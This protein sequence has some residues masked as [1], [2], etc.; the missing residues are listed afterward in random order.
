VE[1]ATVAPPTTKALATAQ[2]TSVQPRFA[3]GRQDELYSRVYLGVIAL[4]SEANSAPA[5]GSPRRDVYLRDL[6]R[7]GVEPILTGAISSMVS[8]FVALG[9]TVTGGRNKAIA[10]R[11]LL[12]N[13]EDAKGWHIFLSK[14]VEDMLVCDKGGFMELGTQGR[15]GPV[16]GIFNLDATACELTGVA[17]WP[18]VYTPK[19][20][21][22]G[23]SSK[24]RPLDRHHVVHLPTM[25]S[26]DEAEFNLSMSA[27]SRALLAAQILKAINDH[28]IEKLRKLPP[29]GIMTVANITE[30]QW[31]DVLSNY[32]EAR[33]KENMSV[34]PGV[35]V[36]A[37]Q[38][39]TQPPKI[40]LTPFS[41]LPEG[42][43]KKETVEIYVKILAL[44]LGVDVAELWLIPQVGATKAAFSIQHM[45][46]Q[47]KGIGLV[48]SMVERALNFSVVPQGVTFAFDLPDD[49]QDAAKADIAGKRILNVVRM[50][51]TKHPSGEGLVTRQE[52]RT[53]LA[54]QGILSPAFAESEEVTLFDV[55]KSKMTEFSSNGDKEIV[56]LDREGRLVGVVR[57]SV[58]LKGGPKSGNI[59]H[60]GLSGIHGGS[61]P[62]SALCGMLI[63]SEHWGAVGTTEQ[64]KWR[65]IANAIPASH[66]KGLT[67]VSIED[68]KIESSFPEDDWVAA[69]Y[70]AGDI[71]LHSE[72]ASGPVIAHEVGHHIYHEKFEGEGA[73]IDQIAGDHT[74]ASRMWDIP[75][76]QE[77]VRNAGL[78]QYATTSR[79]EFW[80]DSYMLWIMAR[81]G[82][83]QAS[84]YLPN[85]RALFPDTAKLLDGLFQ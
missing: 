75:A 20:T 78:R 16:K 79:G 12:S 60:T 27:V 28:D 7:S 21:G 61:D 26:P 69:Y 25:P 83:K 10:A 65:A 49:E 53:I 73:K 47:G 2:T 41:T 43:N 57:P 84:G 13:A 71:A 4:A 17:D 56:T 5:R 48:V 62:M 37:G 72:R 77:R 3:P 76:G 40:E 6:V 80:A 36:L 51:E 23:A 38:S 55:A 15:S 18:V 85:Y 46:A 42:F 9:W 58:K 45:K 14:L 1:V 50:Y 68:E 22:R 30:S 35:M 8:R 32:H 34:F 54:S 33:K 74:I 70:S 11:N 59:G 29:E 66:A 67:S 19:V 39:I 63:G 64:V 31:K 44:A 24:Q 81:R 82:N 52:G